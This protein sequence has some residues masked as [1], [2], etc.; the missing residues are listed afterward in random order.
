MDTFKVIAN[1]TAAYYSYQACEGAA[2][3]T[4]A[5]GVPSNTG[6][7][8]GSATTNAT[9]ATTGRAAPLGGGTTHT[10]AI[11]GPTGAVV[12]DSS[13]VGA[14]MPP[15]AP[16]NNGSNAALLTGNG[17]ASA[18]NARSVRSAATFVEWRGNCDYVCVAARTGPRAGCACG[19]GSMCA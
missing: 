7:G 14:N 1:G 15:L 2:E 9:N 5:S 13:S 11:D 8:G 18:D 12:G 3:P 16:A 6:K 4:A 17:T 10:T 19:D